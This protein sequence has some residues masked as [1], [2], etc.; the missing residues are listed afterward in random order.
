MYHSEVR[1]T[2]Q[3][4]KKPWIRHPLFWFVFGF[5]GATLLWNLGGEEPG[6]G[7]GGAVS[8][9]ADETWAA[10]PLEDAAGEGIE[11]PMGVEEEDPVVLVPHE[12]EADEAAPATENGTRPGSVP[13]Q[14]PD[15]PGSLP[16]YGEITGLGRDS[17][18]GAEAYESL[19]ARPVA[20]KIEKDET[21]STS[22]DRLDIG[23]GVAHRIMEALEGIFDFR[24]CRPGNRWEATFNERGEIEVFTYHYKP[25]ESYYVRREGD[26]LRG[27]AIRGQTRLFVVPVAGRIDSSL[28]MSVWKMG[29]G[30]SLTKM[31]AG[32]FA[33]DIN[34]YTDIQKGDE[35]RAIVEKHYYNG[36]FVNYGRVLAVSMRGRTLGE[37]HA[38][39]F[40]TPDEKRAEYFDDGGNAMQKSFLRAPLDTT[41]VT[42]QFGFRV[43]PILKKWKKHNGVDFGA[44][45]GTPIW[46]IA[47]GK[48][49]G[50]GWMG[51]CGKGVTIKHMN[52]YDSVYCHLSSI[53][54]GTGRHLRQKQ[55]IGRVG[56]TG[57][58]TG[59]HLHFGLK[60]NG[61]WMDPLKVKYEPGKPIEANYRDQW[62]K[63]H[64]QLKERLDGIAVPE[65]YGPEP[66]PGFVDPTAP[67]RKTAKRR[68]RKQSK[69]GFR[70]RPSGIKEVREAG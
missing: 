19:P 31:I 49:T 57:R 26:V 7:D 42:S 59:P 15:A 66:P 62:Q 51:A 13:G 54:V 50:A 65:L 21:L 64:A 61:K 20:G 34:F 58:S 30:D 10:D 36:E 47:S 3:W 33:W 48:V 37:L 32:I 14:A 2:N 12:P 27:Y 41:R 17:G 68:G 45:T 43:H 25:L 69:K 60:K 1:P 22:F 39:Y 29:E 8:P 56:S 35:W 38:Y 63:L 52:G 23:I 18:H 5:L 9:R 24:R 46:A 70:P 67:K 11:A 16:S 28:S 44:P 53:A 55:L 6:D 40:E 4:L